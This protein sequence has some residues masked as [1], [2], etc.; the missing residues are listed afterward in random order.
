MELE[1]WLNEYDPSSWPYTESEVDWPR[2]NR[3]IARLPAMTKRE[4]TESRKWLAN[5][6]VMVT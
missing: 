2:L 3:M 5:L 1:K 6:T 4:D